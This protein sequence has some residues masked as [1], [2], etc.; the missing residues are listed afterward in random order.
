LVYLILT[1]GESMLHLVPLPAPH[2]WATRSQRVARRNAMTACTT[3]AVRRCE[4]L[5]VEAFVA[6]FLTRPS[7]HHRHA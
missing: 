6:E 7:T 2:Q 3:L 1:K 4:R 5:E